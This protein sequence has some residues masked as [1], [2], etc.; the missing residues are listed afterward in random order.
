MWN[1]DPRLQYRGKYPV[2]E[3]VKA[4]QALID[5]VSNRR[6]E[7]L[8][9]LKPRI[10]IPSAFGKPVPLL[11]PLHPP[12]QELGSSTTVPSSGEE[13]PPKRRRLTHTVTS[14]AASTSTEKTDKND[15]SVHDE[16][17]SNVIDLTE[18]VKEDSGGFQSERWVASSSS[19][20]N[21]VTHIE[22]EELVDRLKCDFCPFTANASNVFAM[23]EHL[24]K[25]QHFSASVYKMRQNA[26]NKGEVV[27]VEK[28][29]ALKNK[30]GKNKCLIV[31]CPVC[32]DVF[33]DIFMCGLHYKNRHGGQEGS[34]AICPMIHEENV[35]IHVL[36]VC[37]PCMKQFDSVRTLHE[38]W[39]KVP[40]H[41]P[42]TRPLPNTAFALFV[43]LFCDMTFYNNFF[44]CKSHIIN[45]TKKASGTEPM[46]VS[47][48]K[49]CYVLKPVK[50]EKLPPM[51]E[52]LDG[53][54]SS[55][56]QN[57]NTLR[58]M[59]RHFN[60]MGGSAQKRKNIDAEIRQ[61][62]QISNAF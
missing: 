6:S 32:N 61:L 39:Q 27:Y 31:V 13:S 18:D 1:P 46:C 2:F 26:G 3:L 19:V 8:E 25:A 47:Y 15:T 56:Q 55:M 5:A 53:D 34:Y 7:I 41:H 40:S 51:K 23:Q 28:Q 22:R 12:T 52:D 60:K 42:V 62:Q 36:P 35:A 58:G 43:C 11:A 54:K 45:H 59:K 21:A 24:K 29:L 57:L 50:C 38:H 33:E 20:A 44:S 10:G 16:H 30:Y 48:M 17:A 49:V 37:D 9:R 14:S 4:R